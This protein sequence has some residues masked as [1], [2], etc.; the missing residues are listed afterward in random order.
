[1]IDIDT[2]EANRDNVMSKIYEMHVVIVFDNR[3][4]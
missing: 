3:V 1:M 2:Y 4:E